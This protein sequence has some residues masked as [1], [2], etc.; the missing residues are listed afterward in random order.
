MKT[1][2]FYCLHDLASILKRRRSQ[3]YEHA[4]EKTSTKMAVDDARRWAAVVRRD[5]TFDGQFVYC[6]K[7]TKIF[8][9]P[10][11][12]ARLARRMNVEFCD[13]PAQ[14][15][16][17][18]YRP[19]K[20]CQPLLASYHPE[21]DKIQKACDLL[22]ALPAN[23]PLPGLERLAQ[24]AGLT[25]HHF[26]RLFKRETGQTPREYALACRGAKASGSS[27]SDS[28]SP[29]TPVTTGSD[30]PV[31][32]GSN[33]EAEIDWNSLVYEDDLYNF[34]LIGYTLEDD[35]TKGL[36]AD[37]IELL[38]I[39]FSI[40]DTTYGKLLVAFNK[41]QVCKLELGNNEAELVL[42]LETAFSPLY[43]VHSHVS[44]AN[45]P[46][47]S[48]YQQRISSVV[49][50]LEY[51]MGKMVDVPLSLDANEVESATRSTSFS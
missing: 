10:I 32:I 45:E 44:L 49:G 18:G 50:A 29:V 20:R 51:P 33:K 31:Q 19:C 13:T 23:A 12:K 6:V 30:I 42:S 38:V 28:M 26:H 9:R 8:C 11:C 37:Q 2:P 1:L 17:L 4:I 40:V 3:K 34:D 43:Y 7:S 41:D 5:A 14:A 25:K 36:S 39:Y 16:A 24:V 22:Q 15:E 35:V 48:A 27:V 47:A 46:E 21:A